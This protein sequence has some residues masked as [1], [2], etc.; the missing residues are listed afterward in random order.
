AGGARP[1]LSPDEWRVA[2]PPSV[3]V[4]GGGSA[5]LTL[6]RVSA[7]IGVTVTNLFKLATALLLVCL[8]ACFAAAAPHVAAPTKDQLSID[9]SGPVSVIDLR[10]LLTPYNVPAAMQSDG[11]RWYL[12]AAT[13]GSVRPVTRVVMAADPPDA[14]LRLFPRRARPQIAQLAS[15]DSGVTVERLHAL[16]RHAFSVTIPPATSSSLAMRLAYADDN[17]SVVAWNE[18]AL[19]AHNRQVAIFLAAV[20]GLIGAAMAIMAGVAVITAH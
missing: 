3:R 12:I 20:A 16:G 17:P 11:S 14:A 15:S 8:W 1:P 9:F 13:N 19:V 6:R 7:F 10:D 4:A 18:P 5:R 2:G